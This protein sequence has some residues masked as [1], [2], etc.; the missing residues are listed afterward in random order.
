M[1]VSVVD[2]IAQQYDGQVKVVKLNTDENLMLQLA[3]TGSVFLD[4]F[5]GWRKG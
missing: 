1:V 2:E 3:S 5:Q 4:D